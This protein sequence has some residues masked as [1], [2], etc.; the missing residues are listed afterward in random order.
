MMRLSFLLVITVKENSGYASDQLKIITRTC[1]RYLL[2][3]FLYEKYKQSKCFPIRSYNLCNFY[4][5]LMF[6]VKEYKTK[7]ILNSFFWSIWNDFYDFIQAY[8][9]ICL[10]LFKHVCLIEISWVW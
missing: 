7:C 8:V 4:F 9:F 10:D 6:I 2:S 3:S 5:G 1:E